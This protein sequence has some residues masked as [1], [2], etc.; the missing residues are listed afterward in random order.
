MATAVTALAA[1]FIFSNPA[2]TGVWTSLA[3]TSFPFVLW[4]ALRLGPRSSTQLRME[5][6]TGLTAWWDRGRIEQALSN[7]LANALKFGAGHPIEVH[8]SDE[9]SW[10]RINFRLDGSRPGPRG[11]CAV[12]K[13]DQADG[14]D[15]FVDIRELF[16]APGSRL[17]VVEDGED[18]GR[19]NHLVALRGGAP[20]EVVEVAELQRH[21]G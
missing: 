18:V 8:A 13:V 21:V 16:R 20:D 15:A 14:P 1:H 9:G 19:V 10:V 3:Y 4:G 17:Q 6:Q 11:A 7:L 2:P 5:A 12:L